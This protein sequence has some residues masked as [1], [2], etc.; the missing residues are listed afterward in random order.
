ML[1]ISALL[2]EVVVVCLQNLYQLFVVT[3]T[4][5]I[6]QLDAVVVNAVVVWQVGH[7]LEHFVFS[8]TVLHLLG[9]RVDLVHE[10]LFFLLACVALFPKALN[11]SDSIFIHPASTC[12]EKQVVVQILDFV[13]KQLL[14]VDQLL[15]CLV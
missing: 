15:I 8:D 2:L 3:D 9:H 5:L 11:A 4:L 6:M 10:V 13:H 1:Q 7:R 12:V 14:V